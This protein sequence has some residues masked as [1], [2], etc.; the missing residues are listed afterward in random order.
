MEMDKEPGA[1]DIKSIELS[2]TSIKI[3]VMIEDSMRWLKQDKMKWTQDGFLR[4]TINKWKGLQA[5]PE[6]FHIEVGYL[7]DKY[8][9]LEPD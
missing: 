5:M 6:G 8:I 9:G 4:D 7:E 3:V 1:K 2:V